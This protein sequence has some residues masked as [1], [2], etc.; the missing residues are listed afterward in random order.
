MKDL[1]NQ[2]RIFIRIIIINFSVLGTKL[3]RIRAVCTLPYFYHETT[4][5]GCN[6]AEQSTF[7]RCKYV[8]RVESSVYIM[9]LIRNSIPY[10]L[11]ML[12]RKSHMLKNK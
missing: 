1:F 8:I 10:V 7:K 9:T 2:H 3:F 4:A 11:K 6:F 5:F 12:W